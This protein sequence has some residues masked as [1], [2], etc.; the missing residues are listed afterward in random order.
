MVEELLVEPVGLDRGVH[1]GVAQQPRDG[2]AEAA[3]PAVVL[4]HRDQAVRGGGGDHRRVDRL[5]PARVDHG[6]ADAVV[7]QPPGDVDAGDGH[8]ARPQQQHVAAVLGGRGRQHVHPAELADRL[9]LGPDAA[10][11]PADHGGPVADLDRLVEQLGD[12]AAVARRGQPQPGHD[13][14]DRAVPHA[15]VAGAVGA[16]DAGPVERHRDRQLVQRHVHQQLVERPVQE[17]R[18]DR[19]HRVQARHRQP[20]RHRHRVL[21]GDADVV[22]AVRV[23]GLE[24]GQP[25]RVQHRGGDRD[26]VGAAGA[27]RD[28]LVRVQVG[29]AALGG[30]RRRRRSSGDGRRGRDLVQA[31]LF[32]LLGQR[33]AEALAGD[34]VHQHRL[35]VL[36]RAAQRLLHHLLV[37]AVD[38]ADVLDAEILEQHLRLEEVL[39]AFLGAVQRAEERVAD[40]RGA[41]D[42]GLDQVEHLLV[43]LVN[44]DR[45]QVAGEPADRRLVGAAVVVDH[46]D[47]PRV[48]RDGD[49]VERLP[50]HAAGQRAVADHRD[51][52]TVVLAAQPVG[53]GHAVGVRQRGRRVAVLH[54][55][56]L[57][58]GP[59]RVARQPA[60]LPQRV[61]LGQPAGQQLVHVGLVPGVEDQLV[62]GRVEHPVQRDRQLD[63]AQVGAQVTAGARHGL[64]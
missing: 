9:D 52:G 56:V 17:R 24:R 53:L 22:D 4:H 61:E 31:V 51:D 38:G 28:H 5:D 33:V 19:D 6:H 18:V 8:R 45:G 10:L 14:Q 20:G 2:V 57:G 55:V 27:D 63:H 36:G 48:A 54:Q 37:V 46:D 44:A 26:H 64:D 62:L 59:A 34:R 39:E 49:V 12:P 29:P 40:D 50:G 41:G 25:D 35:A 7:V 58:L 16:G 60:A 15:V 13:L 47:Q 30:G 32:V 23:G 43:A 3:G 42:R 11:G 1:V 21:L